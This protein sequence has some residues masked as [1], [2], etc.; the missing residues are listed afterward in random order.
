MTKITL[1]SKAFTQ[2]VVGSI[3][4]AL[5]ASFASFAFN[6]L[7]THAATLNRELE[8]GM[9]GSDVGILQTYLATDKNVYPSGMVT[10]YFGSL[11][12]AAV[13]VFQTNN[14]IPSV[15]RVGPVTLIAINNKLNDSTVGSNRT[16]PS[17]SSIK[18]NTTTSSADV[19]WNTDQLASAI[20]YYDTKPITM[21]EAGAFTDIAVSGTPALAEATLTYSH[22]V[23]ING[24]SSGTKY[25][26]VLYSRDAFGNVS[27]TWPSN[28]STAN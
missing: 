23:K 3:T 20:V 1:K 17:I 21:T 28:F 12:K 8:I 16:A 24:L 26:Y 7:V 2:F 6:L 13:S 14:G 9:S 18:T 19:T 15:G 25:Y 11:T 22:S 5:F 10:N 27:V 4:L